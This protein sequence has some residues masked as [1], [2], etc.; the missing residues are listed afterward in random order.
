[1]M[2]FVSWDYHSKYD[3]KVIYYSMVPTHQPVSCET[4]MEK[5]GKNPCFPVKILL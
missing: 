5:Y 1:M 3:G 2:E 4:H